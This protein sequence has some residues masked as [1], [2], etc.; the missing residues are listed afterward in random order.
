MSA[1]TGALATTPHPLGK[2]N[3]PGLFHDKSL[4]LPPYIEN[5]AHSLMTKRGMDKSKAIQTAIGVCQRWAAGGG[6]VKPE[7]HAA[8]QAAVAAWEAAKAKAR[9]TPNKGDVKLSQPMTLLRSILDG[10]S[11]VELAQIAAEPTGQPVKAK[12]SKQPAKAPQKGQQ[13]TKHQLPPGAVGWKHNWVPVDKNGNAVGPSQK[14]KSASEIKDMAGHD[15]ATKDAIASAYHN[16]AVADG[17]KAATKAKSAK[18]AAAA[19]AKRAAKAKAAAA[20]KALRAKVVA[21]KKAAVATKRTAA[22]AAKAKAAKDKARKQLVSQATKQAI[23]DKKAGRSL[24]PSQQRLLDAYNGQQAA[25]LDNLRNNVSL[26]QPMQTLRAVL[27][28]PSAVDLAA[29]GSRGYIYTHN[30][31]LKAGVNLPNRG[32]LPKS[33]GKTVGHKVVGKDFA[34]PEINK[35]KAAF[36]AGHKA[37]KVK[38]TAPKVQGAAPKAPGAAPPDGK[39]SEILK[40]TAA[41]KAH[42]AAYHAVGKAQ[43]ENTVKAHEAAVKAL[44]E[45]HQANLKVGLNGAAKSSLQGAQVHAQKALSLGG[46]PTASTLDAPFTPHEEVQIQTAVHKLSQM[47]DTQFAGLAK[48]HGNVSKTATRKERMQA[49]AVRRAEQ[50][51]VGLAPT[52]NPVALSQPVELGASAEFGGDSGGPVPT[53]SSQDGPRVSVNTLMANV[54]K[55]VLTDAAKKAQKKRRGDARK[56][57]KK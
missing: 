20:K 52:S 46:K 51:R 11:A 48:T 6:D 43:Q 53:V 18:K 40:Y 23:A 38:A 24:T 8:A 34:S 54:P 30:W 9:A 57:V 56:G 35:A 45:S 14:D 26:S 50:L 22:A 21:A 4:S 47:S 32:Q 37:P 28:D 2:P 19:A 36:A 1:E 33:H 55:R 42:T 5:I 31:H 27:D 13:Q 17:K 39:P 7:V 44:L 49:E 15:Q 12:T 10:S 41:K 29:P 25:T 3:G 16:K